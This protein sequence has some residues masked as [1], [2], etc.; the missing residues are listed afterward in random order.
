MIVLTLGYPLSIGELL[1]VLV[2][3]TYLT[4]TKA[5]S[6][7]SGTRH[8]SVQ[9]YLADI[10]GSVSDH[11]NKANTVVFKTFQVILICRLD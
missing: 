4:L 1:N 5:E 6:L 7:G 2:P 8:H 11:Q 10:S 3:G 9:A